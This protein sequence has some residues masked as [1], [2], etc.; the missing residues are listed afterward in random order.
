[1]HDTGKDK[2]A[3][4]M[5][6]R[7]TAHLARLALTDDEA[8]VFREQMAEIVGFVRKIGELDLT[9]IEPTSHAHPLENVLREDVPQKG[10]DRESALAN[11]PQA[12]NGQFSV[13]RIVE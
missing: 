7:H 11:A 12:V 10:L 9:G 13:P 2:A 4:S 3:E 1:M 6:V 8:D 5:D